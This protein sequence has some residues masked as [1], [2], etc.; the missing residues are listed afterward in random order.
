MTFYYFA[1]GS[2]MLTKRLRKRCTTA[3][4]VDKAEVA[5]Y[6]LEFSK[7]SKDKSGKATLRSA[8]GGSDQACG[9]LFEIENTERSALDRAEGPGYTRHNDFTVRLANSR[10]C[11]TICYLA[12]TLTEDLKPYDWYLALVIAGAREH[13]LDDDY[14]ARLSQCDYAVDPESD[15]PE[16]QDAMKALNTSGFSN[17][18]E[19]LARR[20]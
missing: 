4:R 9:V 11:R 15:R 7:K 2:N 10:E 20:E 19:L 6:V 14:V 5:E 1:Y 18:R 16:R 12:K 13:R 17:Y 3:E 8:P